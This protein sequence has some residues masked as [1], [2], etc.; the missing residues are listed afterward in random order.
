MKEKT[1]NNGFSFIKPYG[2]DLSN[3][4]FLFKSYTGHGHQK[5]NAREQYSSGKM[6]NEQKETN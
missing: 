5:T 6:D 3:L 4:I 2:M 1:E